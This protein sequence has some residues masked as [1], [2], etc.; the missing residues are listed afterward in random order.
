MSRSIFDAATT[1][2][3]KRPTQ[4]LPEPAPQTTSVT[5]SAGGGSEFGALDAGGVPV[6]AVGRAYAAAQ[7]MNAK[8]Y[9]Y[10]WGGGHA[11]CGTP[12]RGTGRDP[13]IGFDCSGSTCAILA[14][15]GM[16][17]TIGG[18]ADVSGTIAA[19]WG[20]PG[21]GQTLTVWANSIHVWMEFKTTT[22]DQHFGTGDWGSATGTGGPAFQS[23]MHTKDGF[24]PR[25]WPGT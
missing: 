3:L 24:T 9:P 2:T 23:R 25:H 5:T 8:R 4:P 19:R 6:E 21:E 17:Y 12:D 18:P 16:G 7:A 22:R 14:S 1:L 11:H 10:V 15:A 13:G 20:Q